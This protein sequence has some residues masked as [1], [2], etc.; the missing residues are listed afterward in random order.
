MVDLKS[1]V[2]GSRIGKVSVDKAGSPVAEVKMDPNESYVGVPVLLQSFIDEANLDAWNK[3][4]EKIDYIYVNIDHLLS[5][6]D[7]ETH[8]TSKVKSEVKTGKKLLFKPNIVN[9]RNID[10][11]TH[12][13]GIGNPACTEW[14]FVAA[15]M[16]WFHDKL[17]ISF[18]Q[19]ML[20]EAASA[21]SIMA[22]IFSHGYNGGRK[23]TTES[24]IEGRTGDF[25]GG[26]GFYF[27][28]KYLT[29][30]H[31]ASH[32]DNPMNGY[33]E[34]ITGSYLPP[35]QTTDKLMVYD[36]NRLYDVAGKQRTVPVP[37]GVNYK[38]ILKA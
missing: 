30:T 28:R 20:G 31:E 6:L 24:V 8:F 23:I 14:P 5:Q 17:D 3:I 19:M 36:L 32:T 26:W 34:S 11:V 22:G 10:P 25:Y 9:P 13:E 18:Y 7:R 16:R 2:V 21:T 37:E 12:E 33:E 15:L 35:G 4:K 1:T 38:E 29:E 27:V